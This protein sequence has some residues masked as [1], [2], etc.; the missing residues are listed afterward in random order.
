LLKNQIEQ[1]DQEMPLYLV[2]K[3]YM[4]ENNIP[5]KEN[6]ASNEKIENRF[7]DAYIERSNKETDELIATESDSFLSES[8]AY[9]KKH[10]AEFLYV[11]SK[12]F[13]I[14]A[15]DA[16]SL[17]VDDVFGTYEAM[18]G[19]KLKKNQEKTIK[20]FLDRELLEGEKKYNLMF[21]QQDGLWDLN[22]TLDVVKS[23][24]EKMTVGEVIGSLYQ[25]IFQLLVEVEKSL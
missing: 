13:N 16:V 24:E 2:E 12:W 25:F 22:I 11:E 19:L 1:L 8:I 3:E 6:A 21:N 17:E 14:I 10:K 23:F 18:L 20:S 5:F 9:F 15:V 4:K 7:L